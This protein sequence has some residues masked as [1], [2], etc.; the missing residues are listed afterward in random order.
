MAQDNIPS[1][2][3]S[4]T[5]LV[6]KATAGLRLLPGEK[7][8]HL[9]DRVSLSPL[10]NVCGLTALI[11]CHTTNTAQFPLSHLVE[12]AFPLAV[13]LHFTPISDFT[14]EKD[15]SCAGKSM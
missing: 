15:K 13:L 5:P 14:L 7:A 11:D 2:V 10:A 3:W 9:L 1:S 12:L 4:S 8:T 6:L